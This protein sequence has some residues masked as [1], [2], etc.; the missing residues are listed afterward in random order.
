[1]CRIPDPVYQKDLDAGALMILNSTVH[2]DSCQFESNFASRGGGI[3]IACFGACQSK[4][5][6]VTRSNFWNNSAITQGGSIFA[7]HN[8]EIKHST[9]SENIADQGAAIHVRG[10]FT[11]KSELFLSNV[12]MHNNFAQVGG[13]LFAFRSEIVISNL[14]VLVDENDGKFIKAMLKERE[15]MAAELITGHQV[16]ILMSSLLATPNG[17]KFDIKMSRPEK[18]SST[19]ILESIPALE[20]G[21]KVILKRYSLLCPDG[22]TFSSGIHNDRI[23]CNDGCHMTSDYQPA[24]VRVPMNMYL[25]ER[26][27]YGIIADEQIYVNSTPKPCPVPGGNCTFGCPTQD[28]CNVTVRPLPGY[29]GQI[30]EGNVHFIRCPA[31]YCCWGPD[32]RHIYSCHEENMRMGVLCGQCPTNYTV[33]LFSEKCIEIKKCDH[34]WPIFATVGLTFIF[35][36]FSIFL[37]IP[38]KTSS[39]HSFFQHINER[40]QSNPG[41]SSNICQMQHPGSRVETDTC[42][43]GA[44]MTRNNGHLER[45]GPGHKERRQN[46]VEVSK[47]NE[48]NENCATNGNLD[49]YS[50]GPKTETPEGHE[51]V[52]NENVQQIGSDHQYEVLPMRKNS[53]AENIRALVTNIFLQCVLTVAFYI[54][55]IVL[56]YSHL[57]DYVK[58]KKGLSESLTN[59]TPFIRKIIN[60]HADILSAID[61]KTCMFPGMTPTIKEVLK[62]T[63]YP[64][65]MLVFGLLYLLIFVCIPRW[66]T[67]FRCLNWLS[68]KFTNN[69]TK[70]TL[71]IGFLICVSL[72]FQQITGTSLNLVKCVQIYDQDK[73]S[74]IKA[75]WSDA[76]IECYTAWQK[77]IVFAIIILYCFSLP[78]FSSLPQENLHQKKFV[79]RHSLS[80]FYYQVY[81]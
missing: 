43:T 75:L 58:D 5:T 9:F 77:Y 4:F 27:G 62:T 56:Y 31:G 33:A 50:V 7:S 47:D 20:S 73:K 59:V 30:V 46:I 55:D 38:E 78:F 52:A 69:K 10:N 51:N 23:Y 70:I 48:N 32:C 37:G 67:R 13:S 25:S 28:D 53:I 79:R 74:M 16:Y 14:T 81:C 22:F 64:F 45:G 41:A 18:Y 34:I 6:R 8:L 54:Q 12:K 17:M 71:S 72:S 3:Y 76:S 24:C 15:S 61:E 36:S 68:R 65:S 11:Q 19:Y 63:V 42:S 29:W 60:F 66:S 80:V 57:I 35:V 39:L 40:I 26:D 44:A 1:M 2:V 49:K 21:D